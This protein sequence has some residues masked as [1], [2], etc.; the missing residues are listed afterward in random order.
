MKK[1][2]KNILKYIEEYSFV[3]IFSILGFLIGLLLACY[4]NYRL[5]LKEDRLS[6]EVVKSSESYTDGVMQI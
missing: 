4:L 1:T 6:T 2:I 5:T 3:V